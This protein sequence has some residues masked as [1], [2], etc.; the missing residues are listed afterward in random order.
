VQ[1][2]FEFGRYLVAVRTDSKKFGKWLDKTFGDHKSSE[3]LSPYYSVTVGEQEKG[4]VGKPFHVLRRESAELGRDLDLRVVANMLRAEFESLLFADWKDALYAET[5][6]AW[7]NGSAA[8]TSVP[9]GTRLNDVWRKVDKAGLAV[10]LPGRIAVDPDS[11]RLVPIPRRLEIPDEALDELTRI[12]PPG[13]KRRTRKPASEEP[14]R[15]TAVCLP[16]QRPGPDVEYDLLR[17][18][19]RAETVKA[20]AE[21]HAV[22][23]SLLG[24]RGLEALARMT[25]GVPCYDLVHKNADELLGGLLQAFEAAAVPATT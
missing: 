4:R 11:G 22:N 1:Q 23:L 7:Q 3:E 5:V 14:P 17:P 10:P 24:A 21:L 20:I 25:E 8:L 13:A 19:S 16:A 9:A 18:A 12:A 2:T 15:I 6:I